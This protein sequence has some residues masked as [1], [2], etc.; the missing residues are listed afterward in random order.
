MHCV[1]NHD[2]CLTMIGKH[3]HRLTLYKTDRFD[4]HSQADHGS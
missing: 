3:G 2:F 4:G 1:L